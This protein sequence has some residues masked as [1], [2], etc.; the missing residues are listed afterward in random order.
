MKN[1]FSNVRPI[2]ET[3]YEFP[4]STY[5]IA[6]KAPFTAIITRPP[7]SGKSELLTNISN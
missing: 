7:G 2:D 5:E 3:T 6:S 4:Q 1:M